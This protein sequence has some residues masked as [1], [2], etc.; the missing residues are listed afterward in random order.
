MPRVMN[1]SSATAHGLR[2][3]TPARLG[4]I[5]SSSAIW[6]PPAWRSVRLYADHEAD[7]TRA[8]YRPRRRGHRD[9][10][11][12]GGQADG[13]DGPVRRRDPQV[14]RGGDHAAP[15]LALANSAPRPVG[16][17]SRTRTCALRP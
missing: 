15:A 1:G 17:A 6:E 11:G 16:A 8:A 13:A 9:P 2:S 4:P 7:A 5:S 14:Q 3:L 12:E 10:A